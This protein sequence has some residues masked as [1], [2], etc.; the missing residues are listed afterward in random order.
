MDLAA[1]LYA[2]LS[3]DAAITSLLGTF[4]SGPSIHTRR[5]VPEEAGYPM[6]IVSA[7]V[8]VTDEDGLVSRR[9]ILVRD[10][11]A[12]GEQDSQYRVVE[13]LADLLRTKFH[14]QR[15]SFTISGFHVVD[16]VAVGPIPGPTDDFNHVARVVTL[17]IRLVAE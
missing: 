1:P 16:V 17:T 9:P 7:N 12:Y 11:I 8:G 6:L 14:R 13:Q 4:L 10:I 3:A 15:D 2:A 5:P